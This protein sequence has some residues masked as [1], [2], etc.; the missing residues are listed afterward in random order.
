MPKS[1]KRRFVGLDT[2][3]VS[4]VDTP[5]NEVDFLVI[6]NQEGLGM[7]ATAKKQPEAV[8][9]EVT[10]G[11]DANVTK[12]LEHVNG[13]VTK[14]A[15][16]VAV[17]KETKAPA[18]GDAPADD[19]ADEDAE[20]T[21]TKAVTMESVFEEAGLDAKTTKVL[22]EKLKKAFPF[23]P[24]KP[25]KGKPDAAS[26]DGEDGGDE[27][28]TKKNK[29]DDKL[30]EVLAEEPLTMAGLALAV[31]KAAAFTPQRIKALQSAQDILKLVL[32]SVAPMASPDANV[33]VVETHG[34]PSSVTDL[35]K[36]NKKPTM[37][38]TTK[39]V[40]DAIV[41]TL[42]GLAEA[43]GGLVERV[44]KIEKVRGASNSAEP[45][46]ATDTVTKKASSIWSGVL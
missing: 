45:D 10:E 42:K 20:E 46:G 39:S 28:K 35:T 12:A 18:D 1:A 32:E 30:T 16:L 44:E 23:P 14:L 40:D 29:A 34:N 2:E 31:Q 38:G 25:G 24:K 43:V 37:T 27:K 9:L 17:K 3:E 41:T 11:G 19:D 33:P 26:A 13:I 7:G 22:V 8:E 36:P 6:K 4:L 5:A 21:T 15:G